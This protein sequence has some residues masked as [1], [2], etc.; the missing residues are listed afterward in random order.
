M[1]KITKTSGVV[2]IGGGFLYSVYQFCLYLSY[3]HYLSNIRKI[4]TTDPRLKITFDEYK[5]QSHKDV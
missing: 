3:K 1:N 4:S 2:V 5:V